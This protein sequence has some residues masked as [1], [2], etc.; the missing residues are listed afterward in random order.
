MTALINVIGK[1]FNLFTVIERVKGSNGVGYWL[2]SC[3]CGNKR[4]LTIYDLKTGKVKSC[5]CLRPKLISEYKT[6]HGFASRDK[7]N[8]SKEYVTWCDIKKR[9]TNPNYK[10]YKDYGGRGI[11][12]DDS[13]K[14]DFPMFLKDVGFAPSSKHSIDRIDNEKGYIPGNLRW[15]LPHIQQ[16]N[17][18][19]S[20]LITFN[21]ETRCLSDWCDIYDV[22]PKLLWDRLNSGWS[23]DRALTETPRAQRLGVMK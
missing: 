17:K 14:N 23:V 5:G 16:R 8:R 20:R 2:C 18:R 19:N 4:N 3:D 9:C 15:V 7:S 13:F 10:Q 6:K 11:N 21:G 1:K 12:I 22:N